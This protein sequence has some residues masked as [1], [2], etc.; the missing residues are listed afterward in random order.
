[1]DIK[2]R[3]VSTDWSVM[4]GGL[5]WYFIGQPKTGKTTA[6]SQWSEKGSDGVLLLDSDLGVDFVNGANTVTVTS[7]NPPEE[8]LLDSDGNPIYEK[9]GKPSK[10]IIPPIER[11]Q[12]HRVGEN[13]GKPMEAYSL[14]EVYLWLVKEWDSL[15][16]DTVVFDTIDDINEWIQDAVVEELGISAMGE[17]QWGA[18]W[19]KARRRNLDIVKR[20]QSFLKSKGANLILISH[21][22]STQ[23]TDSKVQLS[24][25]LPRG[26][27]YALTAKADV[28]GYCT[29]DKDTKGYYV[30]FQS[31][32]ERTVGSRLKPLSQQTLELSYDV[33]K[34]KITNYEKEKKNAKI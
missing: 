7:L 22:K 2:V 27:A 13:K 25:D 29:A 20:F 23:M 17:G 18:D 15:P 11:G 32:D 19:G 3:S 33:I 31:Y 6:A 5:T 8:S 30:S 9:S 26:L 21:A 10:R 1:M 14:Q 12:H 28:I 4:P 16:Y 34:K 24:P